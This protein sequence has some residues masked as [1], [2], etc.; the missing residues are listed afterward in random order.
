MYFLFRQLDFLMAAN[1]DRPSSTQSPVLGDKRRASVFDDRDFLDPIKLQCNDS[2]TD[3][4]IRFKIHTYPGALEIDGS[5]DVC[6]E[7]PSSPPISTIPFIP[8]PPPMTNRLTKNM[9]RTYNPFTH[10]YICWCCALPYDSTLIYINSHTL[11]LKCAHCLIYDE[12]SPLHSCPCMWSQDPAD[13]NKL[14]D[15]FEPCYDDSESELETKLER[16]LHRIQQLEDRHLE[17]VKEV[18]FNSLDSYTWTSMEVYE[19]VIEEEDACKEYHGS[20]CTE[21]ESEDD[22]DEEDP[23]QDLLSASSNE[24]SSESELPS[25][26]C[27]PTCKELADYEATH[28]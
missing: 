8:H 5:P 2:Y 14:M 25:G 20:A 17:P 18:A 19:A 23:D 16:R 4:S 12:S 9:R 7:G 28:N 3:S 11:Q 6:D 24:S 27:A 22:D 21:K 10:T 1:L 15:P 13:P 26:S